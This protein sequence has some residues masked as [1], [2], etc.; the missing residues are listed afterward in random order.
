MYCGAT[1]NAILLSIS[2]SIQT[3]GKKKNQHKTT[4][5]S[6][7]ESSCNVDLPFT[8]TTVLSGNNLES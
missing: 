5:K 8:A 1:D 4:E 2:E 6:K 3:K 7:T